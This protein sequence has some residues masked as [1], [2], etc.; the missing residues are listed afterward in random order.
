LFSSFAP[1]LLLLLFD[2]RGALLSTQSNHLAN[3]LM[4]KKFQQKMQK[5]KRGKKE[6]QK[7]LKKR[8]RK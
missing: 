6:K 4:R 3:L 1:T 5:M 7:E 8:W 2:S